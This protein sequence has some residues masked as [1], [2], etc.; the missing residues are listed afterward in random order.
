MEI[1][2]RRVSIEEEL[3][4]EF[5]RFRSEN[6]ELKRLLAEEGEERKK[7]L[8]L[9]MK[10]REDELIERER[11]LNEREALI[12]ERE[13]SLIERKVALDHREYSIKGK[14]PEMMNIILISTCLFEQSWVKSCK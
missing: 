6:E 13:A 14:S 8:A 1:A 11:Q 12:L 5:E 10:D 2:M 9:A 3:V 7:A 4:Q